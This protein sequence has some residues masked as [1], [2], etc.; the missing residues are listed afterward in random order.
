[1]SLAE[2]R[3]RAGVLLAAPGRGSALRE[4]LPESYSIFASIDFSTM[5]TPALVVAG[6]ADV[7]AHLTTAGSAWFADPYLLSPSPKALLTLFGA[8]HSLGGVSGY[9]V[10]ETTDESPERV[11]L[12]QHLAW[13]YLR[14]RL[15]GELEWERACEALTGAAQPL[16]RVESR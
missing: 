15:Y 9:D 4:D 3:I 8:G 11:A 7:A 1:M 13:A 2:P 5:T 10:A 12:V 6:D 16:G 14:A